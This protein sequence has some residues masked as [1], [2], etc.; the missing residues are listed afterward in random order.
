VIHPQASHKVNG[1]EAM[2]PAIEAGMGI[3][4][5]FHL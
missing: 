3:G 5:A 1:G 4:Q 2:R